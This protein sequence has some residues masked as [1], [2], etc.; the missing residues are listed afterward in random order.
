MKTFSLYLFD[1]GKSLHVDEVNGFV[2]E[3][4]SGAFGIMAGHVRMMTQLVAGLA[5]FCRHGRE[6]WEYLAATGAVLYFA[7]NRLQLVGNHFLVAEDEEAISRQLIE[8]LL[9]EEAQLAEVRQSLR[10]MEE[11]LLRQLWEMRRQ[12]VKVS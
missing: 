10:R 4:A 6:T 12:G 11:Q 1:K 8:E 2:G 9:V 3:D 5:R 7:G